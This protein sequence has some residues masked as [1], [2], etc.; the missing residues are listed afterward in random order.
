[1][2]KAV[3]RRG[4]E[5]LMMMMMMM[6]ISAAFVIVEDRPLLDLQGEFGRSPLPDSTFATLALAAALA[7][8][9]AA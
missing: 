8:A 1:M 3:R 6:M 2:V 5:R 4:D 7:A 9:T